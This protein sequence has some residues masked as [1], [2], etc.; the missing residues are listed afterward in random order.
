MPEPERGFHLAGTYV[1]LADGGAGTPLPVTPDFWEKLISGERTLQGYMVMLGGMHES[2][3]TWEMHP[4]GE[5][6]LFLVSG[7]LDVVLEEAGGERV[8]R[9]EPEHACL[10]PRGMWHRQVVV[11]APAKLL[12]VTYGE[13]TQHRPL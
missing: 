11:E 2:P 7:V 12:A 3:A 6:L 10:V 1:N 13:G 9:L 4:A 8:I 5:E